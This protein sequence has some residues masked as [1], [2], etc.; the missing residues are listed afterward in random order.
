MAG[1]GNMHA[2]VSLLDES[3]YKKVEWIWAE[4]KKRFHIEGIYITPYPHFSYQVARG[5]DLEKMLPVLSQLAQRQKPFT[6]HATGLGLFTGKKPVVYVPVV[7]SNELNKLHQQIWQE[8]SMFVTDEVDYY[9]EQ[10]WLPHITLA[11]GD[12][13]DKNV[14]KLISYL[15]SYIDLTWEINVDN[16]ALIYETKGKQILLERYLFGRQ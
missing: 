9:D 10:K 11:H 6:I 3:H 15:N 12:V 16:L 7:R 2:V 1:D 5:Y 4:L 13:T 8:T 14:S